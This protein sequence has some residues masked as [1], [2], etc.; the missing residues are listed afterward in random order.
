MR[1]ANKQMDSFVVEQVAQARAILDGVLKHLSADIRQAKKALPG[2]REQKTLADV[3]F[4]MPLRAFIKKYSGG[5][6][7]GEKF[8]LVLAYLA[9]GN[10]GKEIVLTDIEKH[11]NRMT[12]KTLLGMKFNRFYTA[13]AK[14]NDWV[15]VAKQGAYHLRPGW[16]S[17]FS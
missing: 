10:L 7:G 1:S 3:D 6:S 15:D 14:E 4:S 9:K 2:P 17:I 13:Q 16:K 11:W 12:S 8:T 5:M